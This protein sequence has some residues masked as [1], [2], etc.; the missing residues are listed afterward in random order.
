M[1]VFY[2]AEIAAS[3]VE[4]FLGIVIPAR[5]LKGGGKRW[6]P[7]LLAAAI[8]TGVVWGL[9]Q[10]SLF[11]IITTSLGVLLMSFASAWIHKTRLWDT[12]VLI[13]FYM[14]LIYIT[15]F[16]MLSLLGILFTNSEFARY[17]VSGLS[18][19][20]SCFLVLSKSLLCITCTS[21]LRHFTEFKMERSRV[22]LLS[23]LMIGGL[24]YL[25]NS[26]F[27]QIDVNAFFAW[28][29]FLLLILSGVYYK[30]QSVIVGSEK[31]RAEFEIE[32][33]R[34]L[35][36]NYEL[37]ISS[38][39]KNQVFY[40]DLKNQYLIIRNYLKD[41]E[42]EKADQ[43]MTELKL[44]DPPPPVIPTTGMEELDVI[45][46]YKRTAANAEGIYLNILAE[47]VC[48]EMTAPE[49]ASLFGNLLDNAIEACRKS[50]KE[51]KWIQLSIRRI[52]DM[53]FI[54][55]VNPYKKEECGEKRNTEEAESGLHGIG[56]KSVR[57]LVQKYG[58][59][60]EINDE[61]MKFTV[62]ISFFD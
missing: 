43:Y 48:L 39:R 49:I 52:R 41:K 9:N 6:K 2:A 47:P 20:R 62:V 34:M 42:Y 8:L 23:C 50:E 10:I 37:L 44:T 13:G 51:N 4:T 46:A 5:I 33:A 56:L 19:Q 15:D 26:T 58:G 31:E 14:M 16:L 36:E 40:H 21:F 22:L 60:M 11:S 27:L 45:L 12:L 55:I 59:E 32:K 61:E 57:M 1:M 35:A 7:E 38:Y 24:H 25:M 54:K 3:F 17:A 18:L 30:V 53:T 28:L 29:L